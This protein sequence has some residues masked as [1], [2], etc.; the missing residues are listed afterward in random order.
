MK[1]LELHQME[2]IEGGGWRNWACVGLGAAVGVATGN[3]WIGFGVGTL[4]NAS[5]GATPVY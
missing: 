5:F 1:T 4:C 3:P 2:Q